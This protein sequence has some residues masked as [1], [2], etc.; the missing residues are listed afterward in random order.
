VESVGTRSN[1]LGDGEAP[2]A[3]RFSHQFQMRLIRRRLPQQ[4][5]QT[6]ALARNSA[7]LL[8][9]TKWINVAPSIGEF[10]EGWRP[11]W[12][13]RSLVEDLA[14]DRDLSL[15]RRQTTGVKLA[16]EDRLV[17]IE[18]VFDGSQLAGSSGP[19]STAGGLGNALPIQE[20]EGGGHGA[21]S[22][23]G[24]WGCPRPLL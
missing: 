10:R 18:R 1:P 20:E 17:P 8:H 23:G 21:G 13:V 2:E 14:P 16:P 15:L 4:I 6:V 24:R 12:A 7:A 19:P 22:G 3:H 5:R 9:E 11:T